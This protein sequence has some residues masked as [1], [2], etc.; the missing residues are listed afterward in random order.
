M[1]MDPAYQPAFDDRPQVRAR[2][3]LTMGRMAAGIW[4]AIAFFGALAT[5]KPLRFP[6]T[7][8]TTMRLV[9][10]A[11]IAIATVC[12]FLPWKRM[13]KRVLNIMLVLMSVHI[14]ALAYASGAVQSDIGMIATLVVALAACFLPVRTGVAQVGLIAVLLAAGLIMIDKENAQI[15]ALRT[16]LLLAVLVVLLGLVLILRALIAEREAHLRRGHAFG[17]GLLESRQLSRLLDRENSRAGR[18]AR[19]LTLV[20][21]DVSGRILD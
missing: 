20:M 17:S 21:L 19:P 7:N 12:F 18:H 15:E 4:A 1:T 16:T 5:V 10:F 2:D 9:V 13:P 14:S 3:E 8:V 6:D 11:A